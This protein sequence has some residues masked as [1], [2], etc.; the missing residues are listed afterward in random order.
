MEIKYINYN[1]SNY[2]TI[3]DV[4][5][6]EFS[7]SNSLITKLK[8]NESILLNGTFSY[9]DKKIFDGDVIT[10]NFDYD[11]ENDI[12]PTKQELHILF[13]DEWLLALSKPP[14]ISVHPSIRH[15]DNSLSN[16]VSYYY[17]E[18]NLHKK[19]HIV[20]RLD[21][22][23]S[24]IVIIAKTEYIQ[25]ALKQQRDKN[26]FKKEY[27]AV[28]EGYL[29]KKSGTIN[30]PISRKE[31]SII[32]RKIDFENG[33]HS[34]SHYELIRNFKYKNTNTKLSLVKYTLETR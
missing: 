9:L 1:G 29:D 23:T 10:V 19:I 2:Y 25:E 7:I 21:L 22:G 20:N 11:E 8:K 34:I 18:I 32:E 13:E 24:G 3:R 26:I 16:G 4:L 5:K 17:N 14:G 28:L 12:V 31:D 15:F 33:R 6:K 27:L 30:A